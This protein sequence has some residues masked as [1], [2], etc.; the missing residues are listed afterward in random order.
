MGSASSDDAQGRVVVFSAMNHQIVVQPRTVRVG[1][2]KCGGEEE[3][4]PEK[5]RSG[6][7]NVGSFTI[8]ETGG[9]CF[10]KHSC[11]SLRLAR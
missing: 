7:G 9:I 5:S 6:L 10:R 3:V 2:R 11:K 1:R 8:Q 4:A